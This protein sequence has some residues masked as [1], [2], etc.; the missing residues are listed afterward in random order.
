MRTYATPDGAERRAELAA[1]FAYYAAVTYPGYVAAHA[2]NNGVYGISILPPCFCCGMGASNYCNKCELNDT[3]FMI[4]GQL[5][6][7]PMCGVCHAADAMCP[8]CMMPPSQ[9]PSE[10]DMAEMGYVTIF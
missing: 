7:P 8:I 4:N 5:L 2:A 1:A 10:V 6:I 3:Y 9:G